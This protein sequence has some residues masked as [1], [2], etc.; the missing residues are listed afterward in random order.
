MEIAL[1]FLVSEDEPVAKLIDDDWSTAIHLICQYL[2][3]QVV[4]YQVL[5]SPFHR[6]CTEVGIVA[7]LCQILDGRLRNLQLDALWL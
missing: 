1:V 2:L 7:F 4:E 6:S 3:R 5:D